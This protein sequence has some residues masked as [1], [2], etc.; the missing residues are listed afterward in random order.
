MLRQCRP[1]WGCWL[2]LLRMALYLCWR[3]WQS[4]DYDPGACITIRFAPLCFVWVTAFRAVCFQHLWEW[5]PRSLIPYNHKLRLS[6]SVDLFMLLLPRVILVALIEY[7]TFLSLCLFP[8]CPCFLGTP[9]SWYQKSGPAD[10][11]PVNSAVWGSC[12]WWALQTKT[13][14]SRCLFWL[15]KTCFCLIMYVL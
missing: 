7:A 8:C 12:H 13:P 11:W 15:P 9:T 6:R 14:A 5:S 4:W 1:Q 10:R 3:W 2:T